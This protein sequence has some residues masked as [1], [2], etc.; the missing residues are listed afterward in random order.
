MRNIGTY[1]LGRNSKPG[2]LHGAMAGILP[3]PRFHSFQ[4]LLARLFLGA[5]LACLPNKRSPYDITGVSHFLAIQTLDWSTEDT[6]VS[7][8]LPAE[9]AS[10][11]K[12]YAFTTNYLWSSNL[13]SFLLLEGL[14]AAHLFC[15]HD[16]HHAWHA[17]GGHL[18]SP[19]FSIL[20]SSGRVE[21]VG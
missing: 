17:V 11:C 21:S 3:G 5:C 4:C 12:L 14:G 8:R 6:N 9:V 18:V 13:F 2:E 16:Q 15:P 19:G 20:L 7:G 10:E 1:R